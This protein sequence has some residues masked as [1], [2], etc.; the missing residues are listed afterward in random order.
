MGSFYCLFH[1]SKWSIGSRTFKYSKTIFNYVFV[2]LFFWTNN[3]VFVQIV[4]NANKSYIFYLNN[5]IQKKKS[6]WTSCRM[7]RKEMMISRLEVDQLIWW[8]C[9]LHSL[10]S[11]SSIY[12]LESAKWF[13]L[14]KKWQKMLHHEHSL[15]KWIKSMC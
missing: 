13:K 1:S 6:I 5:S 4:Y 11:S 15:H 12:I 9:L 7:G 3:Y 8:T 10:I 2:L 14:Q